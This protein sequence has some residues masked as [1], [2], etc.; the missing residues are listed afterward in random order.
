[1]NKLPQ[2]T[3]KLDFDDILIEPNASSE[4]SSR[5]SDIEL[6]EYY[7]IIT[8]PMDTVVNEENVK[9]FEQNRIN[10]CLPRGIDNIM[11]NMFL[12]L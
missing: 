6:D 4:V 5:F 9:L 8:A 2:G 1:M 7:P 10:V 12:L 3:S 11:E